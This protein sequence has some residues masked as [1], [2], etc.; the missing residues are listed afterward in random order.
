MMLDKSGIRTHALSDYES[1]NHEGI[2]E[3]LNVAP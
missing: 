1:W 3:V 2:Q